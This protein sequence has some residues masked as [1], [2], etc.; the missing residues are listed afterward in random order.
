MLNILK[1]I[2]G[3]DSKS[4]QGQ[5]KQAETNTQCAT[6]LLNLRSELEEL[7]KQRLFLVSDSANEWD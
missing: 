6:Q 2:K 4:Y 3:K 1:I 5:G 7:G